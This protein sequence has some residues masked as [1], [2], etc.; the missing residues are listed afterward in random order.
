MIPR[1]GHLHARRD[2]VLDRFGVHQLLPSQLAR[3]PLSTPERHLL[4]ELVLSALDDLGRHYGATD[5]HGAVLYADAREW[6][7][8]SCGTIPFPVACRHLGVDVDAARERLAKGGWGRTGVVRMTK[9]SGVGVVRATRRIG[10]RV[11]S[12]MR[13]GA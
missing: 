2:S 10:T 9:R 3:A 6:F 7:E 1:V 5:P 4:A 12:Q 13:V 11:R 8:F